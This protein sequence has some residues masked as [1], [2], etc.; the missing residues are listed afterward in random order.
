M[1]KAREGS[2][3]P[4]TSMKPRTFAGSAMPAR[5]R[6]MAK[7]RPENAAANRRMSGASPQHVADDVDGADGGG[8]EGRGGD[9]RAQRAPRQAADAVAAR[10]AAAEA[11]AE[12]DQQARR[13]CGSHAADGRRPDG[14][15]C[16]GLQKDAAA[17][18][19]EQEGEPP[20]G[21]AFLRGEQAAGDPADAGDATVEEEEHGAGETDG[22]A[23]DERKCVRMH[24]VP[25]FLTFEFSGDR[26]S[27]RLNSSHVKISYAVFCL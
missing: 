27:T 12:A 20:V 24:V 4:A 21:L 3:S 18:H 16:D 13:H 14:G 6:P 7:T 19:A 10:T 26:K 22:H 1:T 11:R 9:E 5:P 15:G 17:D 25:S 23:A 8:H 2:Q